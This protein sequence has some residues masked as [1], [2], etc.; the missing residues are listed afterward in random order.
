MPRT[1]Y[2]HNG[3]T[4]IAYQVIG[5]GD[6]DLVMVPGFVSHLDWFWL[7]RGPRHLMERMAEFSR[8]I[9][10][11]KR[12]TGLSDPVSEPGTLE[13]RADDLRAVMDAA[14]SEQAA[15]F[16]T[17]EGAAMAMLFAAAH[18]ERTRDLVLYGA[19][20]RFSRAADY[21]CGRDEAELV[22]FLDALVAGWGAGV[23][24][25]V[26]APSHIG[27]P[28][29]EEWFASAQRSGASPAMVRQLFSLWT[30]MDVRDVLSAIHVPTLVLHRRGDRL[31][32][33][34]V[35]RYLA[36]HIPGARYVELDGIDHVPFSGDID[37]LTAEVQEFIT[38]S[39]PRLAVI[40]RVLATVLFVDIAG[41]TETAARVGDAVWAAIR[42]RF[43]VAARAELARYDGTEVDVAGDGLFAT[44]TGPA[45]AIRCALAIRH[46]V[47][48]IGIRVRAGVH[49]GEVEREDGRGVSG[50]AVH[51][52]ARVMAAAEPGEVLVS[53]TVKDLVV[54]SGLDFADRGLRQLRGVPGSWPLFAV[55]T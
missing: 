10:F 11:D 55:A 18:P 37:Q 26:F 2:A 1:R 54:G 47:A 25:E 35:G 6:L 43:L 8:L 51:I 21:P 22:R 49:A 9:V 14:G 40:D 53:G 3:D 4:S 5:S 52:G 28:E 23:G 17:S 46:T 39:R 34:S 20:P 41:S 32:D 13:E 45:R 12:G 15:V 38:G 31:F 7:G 27:D 44:F 29:F 42:T 36:D 48:D 30:R 33:V 19:T 16:G 50:L 24:L